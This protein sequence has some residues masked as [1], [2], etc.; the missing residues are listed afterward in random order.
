MFEDIFRAVLLEQFAKGLVKL[1]DG[2]VRVSLFLV[3]QILPSGFSADTLLD[4]RP[5]LAEFST[6]GQRILEMLEYAFDQQ[7]EKVDGVV[8]FQMV[9]RQQMLVSEEAL[10]AVAV[11]DAGVGSFPRIVP[12]GSKL[13][14]FPAG[15]SLTA[16]FKSYFDGSFALFIFRNKKVFQIVEV[17]ILD[18]GLKKILEGVIERTFAASVFSVNKHVFATHGDLVG[19]MESFVVGDLDGLNSHDSD[20]S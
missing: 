3:D 1:L 13:I 2:T 20:S 16:W 11:A 17:D 8:L 10:E 5:Q 4:I 9:N 19:A 15:L 7:V 6:I 18:G 14:R 12:L